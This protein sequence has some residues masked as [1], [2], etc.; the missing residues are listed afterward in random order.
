MTTYHIKK[1][2]NRYF[3]KSK[4]FLFPILGIKKNSTY[5]PLDVYL[6]WENVYDITDKKLIVT[7]KKH[8]TNDWK[9]YISDLM[10][11]HLFNDYH[12]TEDDSII[13]LSF[14]LN[15][16][17][18]DYEKVLDGKYSKV[19]NLLKKKIRDY[20]SFNSPEWTYM[21]SFLFPEKYTKFY[22]DMLDVNEEHIR[23]TGE[24][25]DKPNLELETLKIKPYAKINDVDKINMESR[26]NI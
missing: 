5:P 9:K 25:C 1:L 10:N 4:S 24:L 2:Y 14:D 20:Y 12:L 21:E 16:V 18:D 8:D 11:N 22:S 13:V 26:E 7:Y 6:S 15:C 19:S 23:F 17:K 3:Q